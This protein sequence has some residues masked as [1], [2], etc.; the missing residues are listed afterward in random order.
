MLTNLANFLIP[1]CLN[2]LIG[3]K[4]LNLQKLRNRGKKK[5]AGNVVGGGCVSQ[6]QVGRAGRGEHLGAWQQAAGQHPAVTMSEVKRTDTEWCAGTARRGPGSCI[7][8]YIHY[9]TM[10]IVQLVI[11]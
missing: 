5:F 11:E 9:P 2:Y 1:A 7:G 6:D 8:Y 10:T 3:G 4:F